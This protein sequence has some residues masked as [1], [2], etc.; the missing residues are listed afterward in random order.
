MRD[1]D[2]DYLGPQLKA[3]PAFRGFLRAVEARFYRDI[4]LPEPVIDLG[5]GDGHFAS[6]TFEKSLTFGIDPWWSPLQEAGQYNI[7]DGLA[8]SDGAFI[9]A[10]NE[11]FASAVSNSVL[12]HIEHLD[13]VLI[14]LHRVLKPGAMFVF[15][16]PSH[17]FL[18]FLSISAGLRNVGLSGLASKYEAFFNKI[19]RHHTCDSAEQWT[20]RLTRTG[21][22]VEKHW[23][24]FS[25]PALR[26]LEWGHYWGLPSLITKKLFNKWILWPSDANL[27][28]TDFYLR[29]YYDEPLPEQGAYVFF[30]AR[31]V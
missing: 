23:Y 7:Y 6:E 12:E 4:E 2:Y 26:A 11:Y 30:I 25:K 15:C 9:P 20:E 14:E 5:C 8:Q 3:M 28:L 22:T 31:R 29:R 1:P 24:Y 16:S 19:S 10:P 13:E 18:P 21:Y 17:N 27:A